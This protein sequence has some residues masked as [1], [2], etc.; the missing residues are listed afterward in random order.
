[1]MKER[2]IE[3]ASI[4]GNCPSRLLYALGDPQAAWLLQNNMDLG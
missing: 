2:L 4:K 1:M 3:Q